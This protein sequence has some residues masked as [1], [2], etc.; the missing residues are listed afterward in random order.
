MKPTREE[1]EALIRQLAPGQ[2]LDA[3][4]AIRQCAAESSFDQDA[5]STCGAIG[6]MQLMPA[7]AVSLKVDPHDWEQ[8]L[9]GGLKYMGLLQHQYGSYPKALAAYNWGPG[10]MNRLLEEHPA[11]WRAH[12]PAETA[13]YLNRILGEVTG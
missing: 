2:K 11:D 4:A 8:N 1:V 7:T 9:A 13:H 6:L 3:E 10:H 5:R 12:L